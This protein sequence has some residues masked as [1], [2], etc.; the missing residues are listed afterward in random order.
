MVR[1]GFE[2]EDRLKDTLFVGTVR[3]IRSLY[4]NLEAKTSVIPLHVDDPI[5]VE[6]RMY[7]IYVGDEGFYNVENADSCLRMIVYSN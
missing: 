1:Y 2:T 4:K 7:G 6:D 5:F 3:E